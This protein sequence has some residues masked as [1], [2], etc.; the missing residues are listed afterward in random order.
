MI[1][2]EPRF[3][4]L[5]AACWMT[6]FAVPLA[7]RALVLGFWGIA[8]YTLYAGP[9][10]V[11]VVLLTLAALVARGRRSAWIVGGLITAV[12]AYYKWSAGDTVA[13][14]PIAQAASTATLVPIG[15]SFLAFELLH[16]VIERRRGRLSGVSAGDLLAFV[17]FFPA[18]PAGPIKRYPTFVAQIARAEAS[19]ENVY[20]GLLRVL[21][22]LFKK[23]VVADLLALT[24]AEQA[25]VETPLRAWAILLAFSFQIYFDFSAY[26]DI[27]IG[28]SRMLGI[29]IQENFNWPYF[30]R[31]INDFWNRWHITLSHWVRDYIFLPLGHRLFS[32]PLRHRAVAIAVLSYL[33][34]FVVVGLW[35]GIALSFIVWGA[36]HGLLLGGY[37]VYRL[38][39][40]GVLAKYPWYRTRLMRWAATGCTFFLVTLGWVPFMSD[41]QTAGRMLRLLFTWPT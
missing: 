19:F 13:V 24:V 25:H 29:R 7:R 41:W 5:F 38:S 17:F 23:V 11:M 14:E 35:H 4:L 28:L 31:N 21:V 37:H 3:V 33:V 34:T 27:A 39:V 36:Y 10:V 1:F 16:V 26:S 20:E 8:F 2:T 30:A 40:S 15:L 22:G 12:L 9:F 32:T 18:R 6:F